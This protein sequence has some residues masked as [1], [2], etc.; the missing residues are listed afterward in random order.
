M[1]FYGIFDWRQILGLEKVSSYVRG[2]VRSS[3]IVSL[4]WFD[5]KN[6]G[7][8]RFARKAEYWP[9]DARY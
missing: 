6:A 5:L 1:P 3:V 8:F 7:G 2:Y 4:S 9:I